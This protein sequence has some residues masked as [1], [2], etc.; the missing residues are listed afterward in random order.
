MVIKGADMNK[1]QAEIKAIE[2][3][4]RSIRANAGPP[5]RTPPMVTG[6]FVASPVET[7]TATNPQR[8]PAP[9]PPAT[10]RSVIVRPVAPSTAPSMTRSQKQPITHA[11][12]QAVTQS[13]QAMHKMHQGQTAPSLPPVTATSP[14]SQN[15]RHAELAAMVERLQQQSA[16][17]V[18]QYHQLQTQSFRSADE[19]LDRSLQ[20]LDAHVQH[21]NQL[22]AVQEAAILELKQMAETLEQEWDAIAP[23]DG[24][25][26]DEFESA[27]ICEYIDVAV[28][29]IEQDEDGVYVLSLRSIDLFKAE[30]EAAL[31]A[32]ALRHWGNRE[33]SR[34]SAAKSSQRWLSNFFPSANS[35]PKPD[36]LPHSSVNPATRATTQP[37]VRSVKPQQSK[38]QQSIKP[39]QTVQRRSRPITYFNWRESVALLVGAVAFRMGLNWMLTTL[40]LP[41]IPAIALLVTPAA[42]AVYRTNH[43]PRSGLVWIYRFLII[44]IGLLLGGRLL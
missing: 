13:T 41:W 40:S 21:I 22:S 36:R 11:A 42:I 35:A 4:I 20:I 24:E 29:R 30:R 7:V 14:A 10:P 1:S 43:T 34:A 18:Q 15:F 3:Q 31:T 23:F 37:P 32:Q 17:H 16:R 12:G 39:Q 19:I 26:D 2:A 44:M 6:S 8:Q 5:V 27:P 38:P 9:R 28:P 25:E 33:K